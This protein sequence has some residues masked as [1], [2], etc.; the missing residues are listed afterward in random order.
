[1]FS[2]SISWSVVERCAYLASLDC[3][4]SLLVLQA[5]VGAVRHQ[6]ADHPAVALPRTKTHAAGIRD[7][8]VKIVFLGSFITC[9]GITV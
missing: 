4:V 8:I 6:E 9:I 2:N 7:Y 1:M 5:S 3:G